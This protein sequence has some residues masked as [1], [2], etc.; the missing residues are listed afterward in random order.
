MG[1]GEASWRSWSNAIAFANSYKTVDP[2]LTATGLRTQELRYRS[3][4][5]A[6]TAS[7][8]EEFLVNTR[9]QR[10]DWEGESSISGY[11]SDDMLLAL[12]LRSVGASG[13]SSGR[14]VALPPPAA[15]PLELGQC[16]IRRRSRRLYT[17]DTLPLDYL[18]ALLRAA[19]GVTGSSEATL[20]S[21]GQ[22][23][24]EFRSVASAGGLYP[25]DLYFAALNVDGLP[26]HLYR[27]DPSG[28]CLVEVGESAEVEAALDGFIISDETISLSR[29]NLVCF[30]VAQPWRAMRKYGPRGMRFVFIE[31]GAIAQNLNLAAVALGFGSVE[32]AST[33]DDEINAALGLDGTFLA[34]AHTLIVGYA[35]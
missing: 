12:S 9:L 33:V 5:Q 11:F 3:S 35:G 23:S 30:L 18:S 2:S 20:A 17:G 29:A 34:L 10:G 1:G 8:A 4:G 14:S 21:G 13:R 7:V 26:R 15:L 22:A 24:I 6:R 31:A 16:L 28:S 27:Y 25:L 32:C 19:S